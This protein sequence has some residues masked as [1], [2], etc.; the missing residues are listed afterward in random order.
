ML[1]L[2][3]P[4]FSENPRHTAVLP[5]TPANKKS[6]HQVSP[7]GHPTIQMIP[8][9]EA[10]KSR[11]EIVKE[12]EQNCPLQEEQNLAG[13]PESAISS[14]SMESDTTFNSDDDEDCYSS[15]SSS[16]SSLPS[17]E[18]FRRENDGVCA[19]LCIHN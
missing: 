12:E 4:D 8:D 13:T 10:F 17:P 19:C 18:I 7:A 15:A 5:A 3:R 9:P 2:S 16:S 6:G 11:S 14:S 1:H